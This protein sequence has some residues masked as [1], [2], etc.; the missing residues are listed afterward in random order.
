MELKS[1]LMAQAYTKVEEGSKHMNWVRKP[2][3]GD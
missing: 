1:E 2:L 3:E